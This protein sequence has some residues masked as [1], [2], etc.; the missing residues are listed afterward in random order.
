VLLYWYDINADTKKATVRG[1]LIFADN[2]Y[3]N[4]IVVAND[5][6]NTAHI[7]DVIPMSNYWF[8]DYK[9]AGGFDPHGIF[10]ADD[11]IYRYYPMWDEP[12][13]TVRFSEVVVHKKY[14]L[15]VVGFKKLNLATAQPKLGPPPVEFRKRVLT[16]AERRFLEDESRDIGH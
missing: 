1:R 9:T 6:P 10:V 8:G 4:D 16:D 11:Q 12:D 2:Q 3:S 7:F 5:A 15:S 13:G 14:G